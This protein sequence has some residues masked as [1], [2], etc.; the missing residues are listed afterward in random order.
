LLDAAFSLALSSGRLGESQTLQETDFWLGCE[1]F[2]L[3]AQP[4]KGLDI[5]TK[6]EYYHFDVNVKVV[7]AL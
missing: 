3:A 2:A 5:R 7:Q 6:I 4:K 1:S